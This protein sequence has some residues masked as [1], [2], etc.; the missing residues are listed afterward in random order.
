[1]FRWASQ[2]FAMFATPDEILSVPG[3]AERIFELGADDGEP[4]LPGPDRA[5]LLAVVGR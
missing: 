5:E 1:V 4:I 3:R 2:L